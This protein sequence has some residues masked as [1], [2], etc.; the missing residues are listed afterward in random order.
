MPEL[1]EVEVA[2]KQLKKKL[3][4]SKCVV[5]KV[6]VFTREDGTPFK[7]RKAAPTKKELNVLRGLP[8]LDIR[9]KGKYLIFDF[10]SQFLICH[11]GMTGMMYVVGEGEDP[12]NS[13]HEIVRISFNSG[14]S[15]LCYTDTRKFG[16]VEVVSAGKIEAY[17]EKLGI[18][19]EPLPSSF[20]LKPIKHLLK[21]GK[22]RPIK[23]WLLDQSLITGIGNI[24]ASE[25]LFR[26][27]LHPM[28]PSSSKA[29]LAKSTQLKIE[30]QKLLRLAVVNGGS[31]I[32]SYQTP[33]G[34]KGNAQSLHLVYGK[35]GS[36]C[37]RCKG[38]HKLKEMRIKGRSSYFC[39]N[40]QKLSE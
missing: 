19:L 33:D 21:A 35:S 16:L 23:D 28:E 38:K 34:S 5:S 7:L 31:T 14:N 26:L 32:H 22:Q 27:A 24:Y 9:R 6:K 30:T 37:P 40:C 39:T 18:G 11:F 10:G 3:L 8:L 36:V 13:K 4:N 29:V 2:R 12:P 15:S 17:L 1:P 25:I 20:L